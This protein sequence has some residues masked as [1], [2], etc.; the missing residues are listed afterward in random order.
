MLPM[1]SAKMFAC[2][3]VVDHHH[4]EKYWEKKYLNGWPLKME[5]GLMQMID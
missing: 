4:T 5:H 1:A 2:M 3:R